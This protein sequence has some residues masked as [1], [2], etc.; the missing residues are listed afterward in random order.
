MR[1]PGIFVLAVLL[2]GAAAAEVLDTAAAR[3]QL[4]PTRGQATQLS[5]RLSPADQATIRALIPLM[6]T[7]LRAPVKY[8]GSIAFSPS[9]GLV[10]E[11]LQGA[12]NHHSTEA[13]DRAA[14]AACD[15][16]KSPGSAGCI[17]AARILPR[18]YAP[19]PLTLSH[20]ATLAFEKT[21]RKRRGPKAFAISPGTGGWGLGD[22]DEA[23][24]KACGA[25]D[26]TIVVRD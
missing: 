1:I 9:E 19:R 12:F 17:L 8:F 14:L 7:Q 23:A 24:L 21:F 15:A 13:A 25:G 22:S 11:S 18:G 6:E 2:G 10:S 16:A 3:A 5:S 4:F 26:C 20:D